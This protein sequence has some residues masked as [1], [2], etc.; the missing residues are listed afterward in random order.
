MLPKK[1]K[2]NGCIIITS[3]GQQGVG[4]KNTATGKQTKT[5]QAKTPQQKTQKTPQT[6]TPQPTKVNSTMLPQFV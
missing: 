5:P 3:L 4:P 1:G 6:K 2:L